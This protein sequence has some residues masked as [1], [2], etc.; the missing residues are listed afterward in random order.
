MNWAGRV[1]DTLGISRVSLEKKP[2]FLPWKYLVCVCWEVGGGLR[3]GE[4][5]EVVVFSLS[6]SP[7]SLSLTQ[8]IVSLFSECVVQGLLAVAK[9]VSGDS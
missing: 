5:C 2:W 7:L 3:E 1:G 9:M 4:M 8:L 6:E